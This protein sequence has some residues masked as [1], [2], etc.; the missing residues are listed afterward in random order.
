METT[1][2]WTPNSK[3]SNIF[4]G[5]STKSEKF[6]WTWAGGAWKDPQIQG[7]AFKEEGMDSF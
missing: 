1:P 7:K 3:S 6:P 5:P 2:D 4:K